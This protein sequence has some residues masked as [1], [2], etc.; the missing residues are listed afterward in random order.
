[1][2]IMYLR[3]P[4]WFFLKTLSFL[5]TFRCYNLLV[6]NRKFILVGT[7]TVKMYKM[8]NNRKNGKKGIFTHN[9]NF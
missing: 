6:S 1:M 4:M 8:F 9:I 5:I 2:I 3:V 7:L